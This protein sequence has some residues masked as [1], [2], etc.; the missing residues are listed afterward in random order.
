MLSLPDAEAALRTKLGMSIVRNLMPLLDPERL[1]LLVYA[2]E[3]AGCLFECGNGL[4][5]TEHS[6]LE[7]CADGR[8]QGGLATF[9]KEA[10]GYARACHHDHAPDREFRCGLVAVRSADGYDMQVGSGRGRCVS[11]LSGGRGQGLWQP[12]ARG[13]GCGCGAAGRTMC[14]ASV[15]DG[16]AVL[17]SLA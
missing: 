14:W 5:A 9:V 4:V 3:E 17:P 7:A 6:L 1:T 13:R 16:W 10:L 11:C 12:A 15:L 2:A 8:L